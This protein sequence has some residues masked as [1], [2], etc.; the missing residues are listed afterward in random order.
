MKA[1]AY[2]GDSVYA[3]IDDYGRIALTTEDGES[4]SNLIYL[5]RE[6]YEALKL[7]VEGTTP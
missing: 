3:Q 6:V 7:Y 1:K 4:A 2:I 5:E